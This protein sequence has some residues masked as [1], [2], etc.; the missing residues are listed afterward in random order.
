MIK[1]FR[2]RFNREV[3]V[4]VLLILIQCM[5]I[6]AW[7]I[8][9]E[10][11]FTD[12]LFS[13]EGAKKLGAGM[14][15]WSLEEGFYGSYHTKAEFLERF[16]VEKEDLLIHHGE[17]FF[18][19]LVN[20]DLYY[21]LLNLI[22][23]FYPGHFTKWTGISLNLLFFIFMQML[24][25]KTVCLLSSDSLTALVTVAIYG[26]SA[27][28]ISQ[29]LY[30]RCYMLLTLL[31]LFSFYIYLLYM[32]QNTFFKRTLCLAV[33][34]LA[35]GICYKLHQFGMTM[36]AMLVFAFIVYMLVSKQYES[37]KWLLIEYGTLVVGCFAF[38]RNQIL[39]YASGSVLELFNSNI[40]H[41]TW[42]KF[43]SLLW[44]YI[45]IVAKHLFGNVLCMAMVSI[46]IL[47]LIFNRRNHWKECKQRGI[48]SVPL[49]V[50]FLHY[51]MLI[52]GGAMGWR[53]AEQTYVFIILFMVP[54]VLILYRNS[55]RVVI[56][57]VG[58]FAI[59]TCIE[60]W[61]CNI[62]ELNIG[63][64]EKEAYL[65]ELYGNCDGI[66]IIGDYAGENYHYEAA[67]LWPD[68]SKVLTVRL[69]DFRE[70]KIE[71]PQDDK[72]LV[73]LTIDYDAQEVIQEFLDR[74]SYEKEQLV[75]TTDCL[76][77]YECTKV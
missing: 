12:E 73:W 27:G 70:G 21:I 9:K 41:L 23:S 36:Y 33:G 8:K 18:D 19:G 25:Y 52:V 44:T 16:T 66:M 2:G 58:C 13:Y 38:V 5:V 29:V 57:A 65:E 30:A 14:Q 53:Y 11:Y 77:V 46:L 75:L 45:E 31:L 35:G 47:L 64:K 67:G 32:R 17:T 24:L 7:G 10:Y 69:R 68:K 28:S 48:F 15:Y 76:R 51:I 72:I 26:F 50:V 49:I 74:T 37:L 60:Y 63:Y 34:L 54:P 22:H 42:Q 3:V 71:D 20:K 39:K 56:G 1:K 40:E 62:S 4:L 6:G 61:N 59:M 43:R 55:K